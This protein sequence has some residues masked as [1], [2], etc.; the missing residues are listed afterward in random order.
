MVVGMMNQEARAECRIKPNDKLQGVSEFVRLKTATMQRS[1]KKSLLIG[2]GN[3]FCTFG[4]G[5][6]ELLHLGS[7]GAQRAQRRGILRDL[8]SPLRGSPMISENYEKL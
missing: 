7:P 8:G 5:I 1:S 6:C 4:I 3:K 2:T